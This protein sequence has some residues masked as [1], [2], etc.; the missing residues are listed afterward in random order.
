MSE[1]KNTLDL[2]KEG[3]KLIWV[4]FIFVKLKM[5]KNEIN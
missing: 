3:L 2:E 1:T 5:A 4:E